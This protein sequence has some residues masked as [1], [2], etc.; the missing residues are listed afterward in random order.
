MNGK[1]AEG[2]SHDR[3]DLQ[4]S[5][6]GM[7]PISNLHAIYYTLSVLYIYTFFDLFFSRFVLYLKLS[8]ASCGESSILRKQ[9]F[10]MRSLPNSQTAQAIHEVNQRGK[11][12]KIDPEIFKR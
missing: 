9:L 8:A 10:V 7:I 12:E 4:K 5:T 3:I 11:E 1:V 2:H 6:T